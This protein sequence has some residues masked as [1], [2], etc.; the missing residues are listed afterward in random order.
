MN[1]L[2]RIWLRLSTE[3]RAELFFAAY[4]TEKR[5]ADEQRHYIEKIQYENALGCYRLEQQIKDLKEKLAKVA[6]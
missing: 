5:R 4:L 2:R 3:S 1:P 6:T